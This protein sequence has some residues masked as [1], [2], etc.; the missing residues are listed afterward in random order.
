M[1]PLAFLAL[2]LASAAL[3]GLVTGV[4]VASAALCTGLV[5]P[6]VARIGGLLR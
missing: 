6:M 5:A 4:Q 1:R 3:A 2:F